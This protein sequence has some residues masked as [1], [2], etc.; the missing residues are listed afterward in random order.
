MAKININMD[1]LKSQREFKRHKVNPGTSVFRV[2]PPFGT[3]HKGYP[4]K[5]WMLVWGL[6]DPTT[7]RM[8]PFVSTLPNLNKCPVF[9]Y[10][11]DLKKLS[12]ELKV[13][14]A[15]K[16]ELKFVNDL[17]DRKSVV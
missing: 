11:N 12:E 13:S 7:G 10:T 2:L 8:R 3:D 5:K 16:D 4:F 6:V 9:E 17:I 15:P 1:S 14:G